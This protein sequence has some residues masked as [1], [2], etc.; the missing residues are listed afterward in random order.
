MFVL[1]FKLCFCPEKLPSLVQTSIFVTIFITA[2]KKKR[3][4]H[5]RLRAKSRATFTLHQRNLWTEDSANDSHH[6]KRRN[7]TTRNIGH[8]GKTWAGKS[9]DYHFWLKTSVLQ[10]FPVD[11]KTQNW[12]FQIRPQWLML[13]PARVVT[14]CKKNAGARRNFLKESPLRG[15]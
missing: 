8:F 1:Q 4:T 12:R 10:M 3:I 6:S 9:R 5:S 14:W 2:K 7:L 11:I 13:S 15:T